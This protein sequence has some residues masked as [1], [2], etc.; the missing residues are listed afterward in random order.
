MTRT[1]HLLWVCNSKIWCTVRWWVMHFSESEIVTEPLRVG[2]KL[3]R[4]KNATTFINPPKSVQLASFNIFFEKKSSIVLGFNVPNPLWPSTHSSTLYCFL[5][6]SVNCRS[7]SRVV[8]FG[9][10]IQGFPSE[11]K[12]YLS[13]NP[14]LK[15]TFYSPRSRKFTSFRAEVKPKT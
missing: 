8:C 3:F 10:A 15:G 6:L 11:A 5:P 1:T 2:R 9:S 13:I 14:M 4:H 7:D 12:G